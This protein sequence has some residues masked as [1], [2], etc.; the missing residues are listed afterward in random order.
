MKERKVD[1]ILHP[2]RLRIIQSFLGNEE[3]T[4]KELAKKLPEIAQATLYRQLDTLVKSDI[5]RITEEKQI[6]G[7]FEKVYQL[8]LAEASLSVND[9]S[10]ITKEE[11][12]KYFM[13]F[14]TQLLGNFESYLQQE[15]IDLERDGVGYRQAALY[16]SE[17][18]FYEFGLN[19][20]K[21]FQKGTENKPTSNRQKRLISTII[22]PEVN[23]K[24]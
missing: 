8:N 22:I 12:L 19:L 13:L 2:V 20:S 9:L 18:E 6:R 4:A 10:E 3:R 17:E 24:E 14:T 15:D 1:V 5:L 7:T 23:E 21:L 16:L 11:H